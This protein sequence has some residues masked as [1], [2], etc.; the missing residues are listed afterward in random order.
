MLLDRRRARVPFDGVDR[1]V[2]HKREDDPRHTPFGRLLRRSKMDELPQLWNVVKGDMSLV[3]PRP[4]L[5]EVVDR[6]EPWQH[7]RHRV[8]PGITGFGRFPPGRTGW[9]TRASTST[10]TTYAG[11]RS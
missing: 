5:V 11:S 7:E 1:R 3:G 6:Y 4:E 2:R 10:S 9:L 8:K